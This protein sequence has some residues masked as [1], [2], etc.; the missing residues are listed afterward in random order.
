VVTV[1]GGSVVQRYQQRV[2]GL[3]VLGA[4]AV[5][6]AASEGQPVLVSDSTARDVQPH[7]PAAAISRSSA[8]RA[9]MAGTP[10]RRLRALPGQLGTTCDAWLARV[11]CRPR[12]GRRRR[13]SSGGKRC[14]REISTTRRAPPRSYSPNRQSRYTPG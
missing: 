5:V 1:P 8:V 2:G 11:T 3:P 14:H 10:T 7:N 6:A 4:E 13:R 9:A 12:S